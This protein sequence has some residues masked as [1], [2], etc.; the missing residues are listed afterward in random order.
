MGGNLH[1]SGTC[2]LGKIAEPAKTALRHRKKQATRDAL[3]DAAMRL[4]LRHGLDQV[5]IEDIAQEANVSVRTFSNYFAGKAE[6]LTARYV[7]GSLHASE[8]LRAR[9]ASE[10]LWDAITGAILAPWNQVS[11]GHTAPDPA[12]AAELRVL[13]GSP[14]I[15]GEI[16]R[17]GLAEG[18]PF[19]AAVA[20]R[21]GTDAGQDL[22][23]RLVAAAVAAA[24]Q[25]AISA[26]LKADPPV[27]LVPLLR[28]AL[29]QLAAGLPDP[30][31]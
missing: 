22:Y 29:E 8:A 25:V 15:Q 26:F 1:P 30:S 28:E 11:R 20:E 17:A 19:A 16:I 9:P 14:A 27:P 12:A 6:A 4:A 10:P 21:T 23:P 24:T 7:G 13:F 31:A 18:N 5:R 3:A 2:S